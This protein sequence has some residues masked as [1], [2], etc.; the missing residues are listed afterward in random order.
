ME[1]A[2]LD[3]IKYYWEQRSSDFARQSF[4]EMQNEKFSLWTNEL[5]Q[6]MGERT[7]L[8]IL[9]VGTGS[10]YM[11]LLLASAGNKVT[12]I[13]LCDNMINSAKALRDVLKL[14][15]DF[16]VNDAQQL[17]FADNSFDLLITRNL[18]WTL[19]NLEK[20]YNEWY[21][22]LRPEGILVN[23]DADFGKKDF[24][25][26]A[27]NSVA[28]SRLHGD[29]DSEQIQECNDIKNALEVSAHRRPLWDAELLIKTG[30]SKVTMDLALGSRINKA[31]KVKNQGEGKKPSPCVISLRCPQ[32][33]ALDLLERH[34]LVV[35][36]G[37]PLHS[38]KKRDDADGHIRQH[39]DREGEGVEHLLPR[40]AADLPP[41][42]HRRDHTEDKKRHIKARHR[43]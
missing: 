5:K 34:H 17:P 42:C 25:V 35:Q 27:S 12:G 14:E 8:Q 3:R 38:C 1:R 21:R 20:A 43:L 4:A 28:K 7:G 29:L 16:L 40:R 13:D 39:E 36:D 10:G 19:P 18:T 31:Q 23:F 9:D 30:F 24:V 41:L 22:V 15:A 6:V 33:A 2:I 11:A 37:L 26:S 32:A